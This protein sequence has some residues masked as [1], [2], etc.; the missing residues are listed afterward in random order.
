MRQG[1]GHFAARQQTTRQS[2]G[3]LG[4]MIFGT[5]MMAQANPF[6]F[7]A[8]GQLHQIGEAFARR[9]NPHSR[10]RSIEP[11]DLGLGESDASNQSRIDISRTSMLRLSHLTRLQSVFLML[12]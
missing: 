8:T 7:I 12:Q 3:L 10:R 4:E 6:N 5:V 2:I 9:P 11:L 1:L